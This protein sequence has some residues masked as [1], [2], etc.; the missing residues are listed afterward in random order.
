MH[1]VVFGPFFARTTIVVGLR[2]PL[3]KVLLPFQN[4]LDVGLAIT[5]AKKVT[6]YK[7]KKR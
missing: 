5:R 1:I 3:K 7:G 6:C 4:L 2:R